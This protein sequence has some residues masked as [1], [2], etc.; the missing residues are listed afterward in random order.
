M[1]TPDLSYLAGILADDLQ[2]LMP[3]CDITVMTTPDGG[4]I[5][6]AAHRVTARALRLDVGPTVWALEGEWVLMVAGGARTSGTSA[7]GC[8]SAVVHAYR[9]DLDFTPDHGPGSSWDYACH[10]IYLDRHFSGEVSA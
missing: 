4:Y 7:Y 1:T 3:G 8:D 9:H 6:L 5:A 10:D 2:R